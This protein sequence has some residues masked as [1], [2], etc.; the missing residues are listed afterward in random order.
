MTPTQMPAQPAKTVRLVHA[1]MAVGVLLF[2]VIAHF[3]LVPGLE[4]SRD[5]A[6]VMLRALLGVALAACGLSLVLRRRVPRRSS[7]ESVDLFW[8]KAAQP[9]LLS[10]APLEGASLFAIVLYSQTGAYVT[11][12]VT[13]GVLFLFVA[14]SPAF[15]ERR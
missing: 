15:L 8:T 5:L 10:W 11:L 6:P 12:A 13:A 1:A 4:S 3:V 7:D 14:L 9:A 2:A